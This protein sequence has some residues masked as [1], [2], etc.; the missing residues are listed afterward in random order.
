MTKYLLLSASLLLSISSATAQFGDLM[1]A[2]SSDIYGEY[3]GFASTPPEAR[4][5]VE[6]WIAD[7]SVDKVRQWL[8]APSNALKAYGVEGLIRLA[9]EDEKIL[10]KEDRE[11]I[12]DLKKSDAKVPVCRGCLHQELTFSEALKEWK[13]PKIKTES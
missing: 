13:L 4:K 10:T 1:K 3:C 2:A 9:K 11:L 8:T 5:I 7:G 12:A 6:A